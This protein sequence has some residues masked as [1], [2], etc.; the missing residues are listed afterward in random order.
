MRKNIFYKQ[1]IRIKDNNVFPVSIYKILNA[2]NFMR[3]L[4]ATKGI[5]FKRVVLKTGFL[6]SDVMSFQFFPLPCL[7]TQV[8]Y[9][10]GI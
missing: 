9:M 4:D 7:Q 8:V 1:D 6:D 2:I 10:D 3:G 5:D